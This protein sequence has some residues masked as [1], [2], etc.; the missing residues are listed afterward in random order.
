MN[1]RRINLGSIASRSTAQSRSVTEAKITKLEVKDS[2]GFHTIYDGATGQKTDHN[3]PAGTSWELRVTTYATSSVAQ[4]ATA[5][6]VLAT[7]IPDA[8]KKQGKNA[9][10]L[11]SGGITRAFDFNMGVM[12]ATEVMIDRVTFWTSDYY[13]TTL[14]P[15][16]EW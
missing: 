7:G 3:I 6:T 12:P 9:R 16:E 8:Y 2:T 11:S 15:V 14:P 13:T 4:W 10:N 5:V 1:D